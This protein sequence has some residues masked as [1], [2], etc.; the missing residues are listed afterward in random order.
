MKIK[1]FINKTMTPKDK[2]IH[3][4]EYYDLNYFLNDRDGIIIIYHADNISEDVLNL[5]SRNG[6]SLQT[7]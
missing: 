3:L 1:D 6:Y 4:L 7:P 5:I 2:L